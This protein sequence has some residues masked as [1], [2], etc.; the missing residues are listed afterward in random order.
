MR[1]CSESTSSSSVS[2]RCSISRALR[3]RGNGTGLEA[4]CMYHLFGPGDAHELRRDGCAD[5]VFVGAPVTR[6]ECEHERP[7]ANEDK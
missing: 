4:G 2:P 7:I 6:H 1:S 5:R 3:E